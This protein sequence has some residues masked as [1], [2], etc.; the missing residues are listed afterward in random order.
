[1]HDFTPVVQELINA[2]ADIYERD[3]QVT[4]EVRTTVRGGRAWQSVASN[5]TVLVHGADH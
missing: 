1:M 2:G 3:N 5:V 4:E